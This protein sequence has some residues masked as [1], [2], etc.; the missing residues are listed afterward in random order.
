MPFSS[1]ACEKLWY[2]RKIGALPSQLFAGE[3]VVICGG[4]KK[5]VAADLEGDAVRAEDVRQHGGRCGSLDGVAGVVLGSCATE[6]PRR[7]PPGV[8]RRSAG[9]PSMSARRTAVS[10]RQRL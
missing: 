4:G 9:L 3:N 10:G 7:Q 8:G 1:A 5:R 6:A 2:V